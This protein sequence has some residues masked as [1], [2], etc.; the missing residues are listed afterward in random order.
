MTERSKNVWWLYQAR[1]ANASGGAGALVTRLSIVGGQV[2]KVVLYQ[3]TGPASAGAS[4]AIDVLDEDGASTSQVGSCAAGAA[5]IL[6]FPTIGA[7]PTH[8]NF[9]NTSELIIGPG[10]GLSATSSTSLITETQ[11]T[12]V[13]LLLS[14]PTIPTWDIT[15]SVGGSAL[16]ANSISAANELQAVVM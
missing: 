16:G 4:L 14:T 2:A 9:P 5:R 10:M 12:A 6:R 15:G 8:A 7:A 11:T 1:R 3:V 13:V